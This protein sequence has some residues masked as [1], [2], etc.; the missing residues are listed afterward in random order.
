MSS[1]CLCFY[2]QIDY[3]SRRCYY[4]RVLTNRNIQ[5][6]QTYFWIQMGGLTMWYSQSSSHNERQIPV[7][8]SH[9]HIE[10]RLDLTTSNPCKT[11]LLPIRITNPLLAMCIQDLARAIVLHASNIV[12]NLV[13]HTNDKL[14]L[15]E[16]YLQAPSFPPSLVI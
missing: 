7:D 14:M 1:P 11:N 2:E 16:Y 13:I 12:R 3:Q 8:S 4:Q 5:F 10:N 6:A 15:L 9:N